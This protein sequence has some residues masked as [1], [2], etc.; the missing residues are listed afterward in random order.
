MLC[1]G[2]E[3][4]ISRSPLPR[5]SGERSARFKRR[6]RGPCPGEWILGTN[7]R[8][9]RSMTQDEAHKGHE[10]SHDLIELR[11][12]VAASPSALCRGGFASAAMGE[13]AAASG[14]AAW[15]LETSPKMT[16]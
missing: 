5:P 3:L 4:L 2:Y 14:Q 12:F 10:V 9:T 13:T 6:V 1:I 11:L 7:P 16:R 15:I 8:M